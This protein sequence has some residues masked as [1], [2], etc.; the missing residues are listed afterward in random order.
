[1]VV[2][3]QLLVLLQM[4]LPLLVVEGLLAAVVVQHF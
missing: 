2:V 1:V 3:Q 4:Q